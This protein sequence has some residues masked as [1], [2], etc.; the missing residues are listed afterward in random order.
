MTEV[1]RSLRTR[2]IRVPLTRPWGPDVRD[3]SLV[4]VVVEDAAGDVG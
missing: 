1:I 2:A 4:E 3:L